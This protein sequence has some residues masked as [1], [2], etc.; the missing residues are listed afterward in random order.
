MPF[1]GPAIQL[2]NALRL[3]GR[4][5]FDASGTGAQSLS[6]LGQ[7]VEKSLQGIAVDTLPPRAF[8]REQ[9]KAAL[10]RDHCIVR[11]QW[12]F[13]SPALKASSSARVIASAS[14]VSLIWDGRFILV[15]TLSLA[16]Q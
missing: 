8:R 1:T 7:L 10:E 11:G 2:F 16:W 14:S 12:P 15:T 6:H 13:L 4:R 5:R 9:L 3:L